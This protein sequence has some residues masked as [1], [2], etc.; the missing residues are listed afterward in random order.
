MLQVASASFCCKYEMAVKASGQTVTVLP[1]QTPSCS[2]DEVSVLKV[3]A[4]WVMRDAGK[5][6]V[7]C[8]LCS[9]SLFSS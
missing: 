7:A 5:P 8:S 6:G 4:S 3:G 1:Y 2:P 9:A